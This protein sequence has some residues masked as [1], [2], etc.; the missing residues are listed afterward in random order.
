MTTDRRARATGRRW[1]LPV[2]GLLALTVLAGCGSA[3]SGA[4]GGSTSGSSE[5]SEG[6]MTAPPAG[7]SSAAA[8]PAGEIAPEAVTGGPLLQ[9]EPK[10][11]KAPEPIEGLLAWDTSG[12]DEETT[13]PGAL[14]HNHVAESV[15]YAVIP[16]VGG[17]HNGIWLNAGV[18]TAPVPSERAVHDLEHGAVWITYR[19]GLAA[20]DVAA[21][22]AF[23]E[24][25]QPIEQQGAP[26]QSNRYVLMSPWADEKLPAPVVISAWGYQLR[27]D[28]PSDPRLQTFVDTFR[29]SQKYSPE[30]G[31]PVDG[32]PILTGGRPATAGSAL[33]NPEGAVG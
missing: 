32:V 16:P 33:P 10:Q 5:E 17:P 1:A 15:S 27:V 4:T 31:S 3:S 9:Q 20:A 29:H 13:P 30:F 26:G 18:Y 23:V 21:L 25:Q 22:T 8:A 14:E 11:V 12:Y 24:K 6:P 28:S 2:A 7:S 19:P